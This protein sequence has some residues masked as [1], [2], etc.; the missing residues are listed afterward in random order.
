MANSS[1]TGN[2]NL[3]T[4][5]NFKMSL[6]HEYYHNVEFFLKSFDHPAVS[7]PAANFASP[8]ANIPMAGDTITFSDL[9]LNVLVNEDM[10]SYKELYY[11]LIRHVNEKENMERTE[12]KIP[13]SSDMIVSILSSKNN[14]LAKIKYKNAIITDVS[15]I[16]FESSSQES[17][18]S[19]TA[20]FRYSEFEII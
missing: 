3:L 2:K 1:L 16:S 14:V 20:S 11:W 17:Q 15:G 13:T 5:S 10:D 7:V 8:R 12:D 19:F 4:P 18:L 9:T 6:D